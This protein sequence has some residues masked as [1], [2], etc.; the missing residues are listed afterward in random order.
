MVILIKIEALD[1]VGPPPKPSDESI[2]LSIRRVTSNFRGRLGVFRQGE[3]KT[4]APFVSTTPNQFVRPVKPGGMALSN[5]DAVY[6]QAPFLLRDDEALVITG[7]MPKVRTANVMLWNVYLQTLD[8]R[9]RQV[10]A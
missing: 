4:M 9:H 2:A 8:Y 7:V 3:E 10:F 5:A 6:S 1:D